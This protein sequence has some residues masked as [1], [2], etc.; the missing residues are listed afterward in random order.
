MM[1]HFHRID[2]IDV[3]TGAIYICGTMKGGD[4]FAAQKLHTITKPKQLVTYWHPVYGNVGRE[5][6]YLNK[7]DCDTEV[8]TDVLPEVWING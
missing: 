8:F 2:E 1:G 6:I 4:E 3:G 5:V 7:Y